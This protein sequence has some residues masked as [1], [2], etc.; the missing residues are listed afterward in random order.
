MN[1]G[2]LKTISKDNGIYVVP[3]E[4]NQ[5]IP[6][7]SIAVSLVSRMIVSKVQRVP[8]ED[9]KHK[10]ETLFAFLIEIKDPTTKKVVLKDTIHLVNDEKLDDN[11]KKEAEKMRASSRFTNIKENG[12]FVYKIDIIHPNTKMV[13]LSNKKFLANNFEEA[14]D[15]GRK[16]KDQAKNDDSLFAN[17]TTAYDVKFIAKPKK[18]KMK[19]KTIKGIVEGNISKENY[20]NL[21]VLPEDMRNVEIDQEFIELQSSVKKVLKNKPSKSVKK[22][23]SS[24]KLQ[25]PSKKVKKTKKKK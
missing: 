1:N 19:L 8:A 9:I 25:K 18:G 5:I 20:E 12:K 10:H 13:V 4:K 21:D 7:L 14:F 15:E 16:M 17:P 24:K 23:K 11:V 2:E 22:S 6:E 3:E